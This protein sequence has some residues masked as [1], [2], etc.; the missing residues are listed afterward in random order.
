MMLPEKLMSL[1]R[2]G[3]GLTVE[4]KK[5][6]TNI[7]KDVYNTVRSFPIEMEVAFFLG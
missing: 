1:I 7:T 5:S 6:T 2:L 3:E 4:F